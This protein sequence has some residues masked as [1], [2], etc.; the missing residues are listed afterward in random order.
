MTRKNTFTPYANEADVIEIGNLM[1]E[2]RVDRITV[3]GDVDLTA[4][5]QGL[6]DARRL[7][8]ALA[9]IVAALEARDLPEQL[10]PPEI[11]FVAN[12]FS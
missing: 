2:N 6:R 10:P 4:D 5:Q 3:S 9:A 8:Q 7:H 11:G 12:P 1:L